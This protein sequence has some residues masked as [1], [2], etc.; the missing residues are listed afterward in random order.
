MD[1]KAKSKAKVIKLPVNG[2]LNGVSH[3]KPIKV[4]IIGGGLMGL[5]LAYKI[6]QLNAAVKVLERDTQP[7]GLSTFYNYGKFTWDKFY[8]VIVPSDRSLIKFIREIGLGEKLNWRRSYSGY[9]VN[10][11]FYSLSSAKEFLRFPILG[12]VDKF[13]LGFTMFYGSRIT[14]WRNLEKKTVEE[15]LTKMGGKRTF[16]K[17]W[18]PLLLAKLGEK[19]RQVSAVFIW[20]YIKRLFK[21]RERSVRKEHMGYVSGGYKTVFRKL[22]EHLTNNHSEI[23]LNTTVKR[24]EPSPSGGVDVHYNDK[25]EH[26]DKVIFT[27]PLNVLEKVVSKELVKLENNRNQIEYLGVVCLVVVSK[28]PLTPYY[29]LNIGDTNT[30][31]TGVIGMSSLIDK[32]ETDGYHL[33]YFPKYITADHEY[34]TKSD[35]ELEKLFLNGVYELY[36]Q[37]NTDDIVSTHINRALKVQPLQVL[38]YSSIIPRI[39]T[40]NE[41]FYVLNTSQF[42]NDSVNNNSVVNHVDLFI[43]QFESELHPLK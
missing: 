41:D 33:T 26:F 27:A 32:D 16:D 8:H 12:I 40:L 5:V 31:F 30:P 4:G 22:E 18:A 2:Q 1:I 28:S 38:N 10:R 13:R 25:K 24:I 7:G 9:Y 3:D 42:V 36:P 11:K 35:A 39:K 15:W 23:L 37:F 34:W 20:T 6:S 19:Y 29:I 17:F 43:S 14:N 21:T